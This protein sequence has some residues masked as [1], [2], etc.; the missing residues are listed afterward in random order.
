MFWVPMTAMSLAVLLQGCANDPPTRIGRDFTAADAGPGAASGWCVWTEARKIPDGDRRGILIGPIVPNDDGT[1]LSRVVLRLDIRHPATGDL[2]VRLA[3]DADEDGRPEFSV[4]IEF[5][6]SRSD[7]MGRELHACPQPLDGT[8]Y[9][10]DS[11]DEQGQVF[12]AFQSL[13]SGH[14]FYLAVAD[15]LA[16]DTGRVLCWAIRTEETGALAAH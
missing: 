8:Y 12:A 15:T 6:R 7:P 3:Y 13:L 9:F 16:E 10:R 5:F 11:A 2:D 14:A 1:D 4:P